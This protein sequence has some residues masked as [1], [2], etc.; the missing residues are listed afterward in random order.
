MK[1]LEDLIEWMRAQLR[2]EAYRPEQHYMRGSGPKSQA[3]ARKT[4][5]SEPRS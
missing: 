2:G 3:R 5:G 4:R 1:P